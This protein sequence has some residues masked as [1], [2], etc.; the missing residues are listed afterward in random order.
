MNVNKLSSFMNSCIK[1]E[2]NLND[3]SQTYFKDYDEN[4]LN[5][6]TFENL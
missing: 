4:M 6:K 1:N 3:F 5:E 2:K